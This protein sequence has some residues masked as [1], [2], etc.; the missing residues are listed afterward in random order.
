M[1]RMGALGAYA[2][3]VALLLLRNLWRGMER[4][5]QKQGGGVRLLFD[6]PH[7]KAPNPPVRSP[8]RGDVRDRSERRSGKRPGGGRSRA[9]GADLPRTGPI[10]DPEG[11]V[12]YFRAA[13]D[14]IEEP[15]RVESPRGGVKWV[16]APVPPPT[17][18][19]YAAK[20]GVGSETLWAW[21]RKDP[22][23][24]EAIGVAQAMQED[25]VVCMVALRAYVPSVG[26]FML[27]NLLGW[28]DKVEQKNTGGLTLVFDE[29]D[30]RA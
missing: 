11:L 8:R 26:I 19:G 5:E 7:A 29:Q 20:V 17:L 25:L 15:E 28:T 6:A 10:P 18:A 16:Q 4:V 22:E 23:F 12:A 14:A 1:I 21:A 30:S 9:R 13:H 3:R 2:P 24:E 27:K